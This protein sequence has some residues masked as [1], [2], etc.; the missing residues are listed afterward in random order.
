MVLESTLHVVKIVSGSLCLLSELA[1]TL[2][3]ILSPINL[4]MV[5][6]LQKVSKHL[7]MR[8]VI[9]SLKGFNCRILRNVSI[10]PHSIISSTLA[11]STARFFK[12]STEYSTWVVVLS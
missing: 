11:S 12:H 10:V 8:L 6:F 3:P 5:S 9:C 4:A 1:K 2:P 7:L